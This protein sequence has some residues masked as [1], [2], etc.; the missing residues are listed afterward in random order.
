V[1]W[2]EDIRKGCRRMNVVDYYVSMY[3]N[4]KMKPVETVPRKGGGGVKEND[5]GG[6]FNYDTVRTFVNVTMYPQCNNMIRKKE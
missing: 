4:G 1:G 3:E 5:G 6:K 2:R